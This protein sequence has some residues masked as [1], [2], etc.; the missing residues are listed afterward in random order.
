MLV[1]AA[2][3]TLIE[4]WGIDEGSQGGFEAREILSGANIGAVLWGLV[5]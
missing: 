2:V 3:R 5:A 4:C 1:G